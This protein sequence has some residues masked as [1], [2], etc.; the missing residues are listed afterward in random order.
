M[1]GLPNPFNAS[2]S[3]PR[4]R[5]TE[6]VAGNRGVI[7]AD[8]SGAHMPTSAPASANATASRDTEYAGPPYSGLKLV[9]PRN[10]FIEV[11]EALRHVYS[12]EGGLVSPNGSIPISN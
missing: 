6:H 11:G 4:I 5:R 9:P 2:S 12:G 1:S 7:S 10:T 3:V 8:W